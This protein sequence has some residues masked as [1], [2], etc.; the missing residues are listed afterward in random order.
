MLAL[1]EDWEGNIWASTLERASELP[2]PHKMTPIT[3]LGLVS[4][5]DGTG[6]GQVWVGSVDA[7]VPF[8]DGTILTRRPPI[9]LRHPPLAAMHADNRG[10]LWVAAG[11][12]LLRITGNQATTVSLVA[13]ASIRSPTSPLTATAA[14]GCMTRNVGFSAGIEAVCRR[15]RFHTTSNGRP[16]WRATPI[17]AGGPG[18]P[19][20]IRVWRSSSRRVTSAFTDRP[21]V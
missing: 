7:I 19:S 16:F 5:V 20:R 4:A 18:S 2:T 13:R 6:D 11:R 1:I 12:E 8:A 9:P 21:T 3:N 10:V 14:S 15:H 17:G